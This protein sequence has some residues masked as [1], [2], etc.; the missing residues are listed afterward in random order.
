VSAEELVRLEPATPSGVWRLLLNRPPVNAFSRAAYQACLDAFD[1]VLAEPDA[2]C[3]LIGSTV[4]GAFS[5]GAD[6]NELAALDR[7]GGDDDPWRE[8]DALT[9]QFLRRLGELPLPTIAAVDGYAIGMGFVIASLCDIRVA[10]RRSWFSIPELA[11][12]RAGGARN[13]MRV[14]PQGTVRWLYLTKGRID[15]QR[16]YELGLIEILAEDGAVWTAA[17]EVAGAIATTSPAV[18]REA[19]ATLRDIEALPLAEGVAAERA[20]SRRMAAIAIAESAVTPEAL[21]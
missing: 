20:R 12:N 11:V 14:L 18:L 1:Q 16:A 17:G 19:K 21:S 13:A 10:T 2:R 5:G 3:L 4:D 15:A 8:R 9:D 6:T 7:A